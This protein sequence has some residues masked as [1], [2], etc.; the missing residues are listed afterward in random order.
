ML[1]PLPVVLPILLIAG[2]ASGVLALEGDPQRGAEI[3]S[4]CAACHSL[5]R[6]RTGPKHCGVVGR[7]AGTLP[8]YAYS[9][10]MRDSGIVWTPEALDRFLEAPLKAL[11]GTKMG[12][13]GIKDP[14]ERADIIAYLETAVAGSAACP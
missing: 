11:S 8:G 3:Y 9:R 6:N 12:Y 5:E 14:K 7:T 4:R 10:S 13:A 1:Q 2:A